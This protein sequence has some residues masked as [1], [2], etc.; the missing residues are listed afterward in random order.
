[1]TTR[2]VPE[3]LWWTRPG[4]LAEATCP[5]CGAACSIERHID[6]PT[7]WAQAIAKHTT[8]HDA[9]RCPHSGLDWHN[10]L[11]HLAQAI[12]T[13]PSPRVRALMELDREDLRRA[14]TSD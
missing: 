14:H 1:M 3:G 12:A 7:C 4:E 11:V 5:H 6:G 10:Q 8:L 9:V 13:C 2:H